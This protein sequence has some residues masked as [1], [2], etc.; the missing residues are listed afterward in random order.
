[1]VKETAIPILHLVVCNGHDAPYPEGEHPEI[2][3][4]NCAGAQRINGWISF[5]LLLI[6]EGKSNKYTAA[7]CQDRNEGTSEQI[8][9][10]DIS[11]GDTEG[12]KEDLQEQSRGFTLCTL[13]I[14]SSVVPEA[15]G[16]CGRCALEDVWGA[17]AFSDE[18]IRGSDT[19]GF[20]C[21]RKG[22]CKGE[23]ES[24][25]AKN[26]IHSHSRRF[27]RELHLS[28][29]VRAAYHRGATWRAPAARS[30]R[31]TT[32]VGPLPRRVWR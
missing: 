3:Y 8:P 31:V 2:H 23:E 4:A 17:I 25:G 20:F 22:M 21:L 6:P 24:E 19:Y 14:C 13:A 16:Q 32:L 12:A 9:T 10:I 30:H 28:L 27:A 1:M 29:A 26:S 18:L 7:A 11:P 15:I 5:T